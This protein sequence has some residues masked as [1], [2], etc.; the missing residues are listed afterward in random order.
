LLEPIY[1]SLKA[2]IDTE[3]PDFEPGKG[4]PRVK[5]IAELVKIQASLDHDQIVNTLGMPYQV[6]STYK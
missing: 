5:L 6:T 4:R 1:G 2:Q 3:K